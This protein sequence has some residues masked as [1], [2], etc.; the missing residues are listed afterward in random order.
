MRRPTHAELLE[1]QLYTRPREEA[2]VQRLEDEIAVLKSELVA[3]RS[4]PDITELVDA[5]TGL[6]VVRSA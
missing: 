3:A 1:Q 5:V 2:K 6:T 4:K